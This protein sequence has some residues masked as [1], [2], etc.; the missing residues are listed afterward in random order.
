MD[1]M[2]RQ[3]NLHDSYV[4]FCYIKVFHVVVYYFGE[5]ESIHYN[6]CFIVEVY[7]LYWGFA[8][9]PQTNEGLRIVCYWCYIFKVLYTHCP[10]P[11]NLE[12]H[13]FMDGNLH[14][15]AGI[16]NEEEQEK[17]KKTLKKKK[18]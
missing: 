8:L 6:K 10:A 13:N 16:M 4:P 11:S 15:Q 14:P 1:R 18:S 3:M 7:S 9:L 2:I 17:E 12:L 5:K